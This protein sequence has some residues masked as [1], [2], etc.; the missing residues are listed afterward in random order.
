MGHKEVLSLMYIKIS[1]GCCLIPLMDT[2][3]ACDFFILTNNPLSFVLIFLLCGWR[4]L[5]LTEIK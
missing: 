2:N 1:S 3:L 5:E 4:N